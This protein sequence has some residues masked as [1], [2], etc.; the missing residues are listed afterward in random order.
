MRHWGVKNKTVLA[1][2]SLTVA[3]VHAALNCDNLELEIHCFQRGAAQIRA[4]LGL[5]TLQLINILYRLQSRTCHRRMS[6]CSIWVYVEQP[7]LE[8]YMEV[9][10]D[11]VTLSIHSY[12]RPTSSHRSQES[13]RDQNISR[14][15]TIFPHSHAILLGIDL[16][17][18]GL[19]CLWV[20]PHAS[21]THSIWFIR[22]LF[23][24]FSPSS[25]HCC[26][27]SWVRLNECCCCCCCCSAACCLG[28]VSCETMMQRV[29]QTL[30]FF[31]PKR[32]K[33]GERG[34]WWTVIA[35][36]RVEVY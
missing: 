35:R 36:P 30:H 31:S 20:S 33:R 9:N 8:L 10:G 28:C 2:L 12:D 14:P 23:R 21:K 19:K 25:E 24:C 4:A 1:L 3:A 13:Q 26:F 6:P 7:P 15:K 16:P 32:E 22:R 34:G 27:F 29:T 17:C 5:C 18:L 11:V